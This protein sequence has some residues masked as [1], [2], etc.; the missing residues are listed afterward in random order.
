MSRLKRWPVLALLTLLVLSANG[1]A[2][3]LELNKGDHIAI[4]G[5][6]LADLMQHDGWLEARLN[7]RFAKDEISIRNLG[8]SGDELTLRLRSAA[9]GSPEQRERLL[10]GG[11]YEG[12]PT[13][14]V[15]AA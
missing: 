2:A 15:D 11:V 12:C 5:N 6:T 8:Y 13:R 10:P 4:V 7:A 3:S 1:K 9:F 14:R